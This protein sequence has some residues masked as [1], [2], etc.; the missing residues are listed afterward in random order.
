MRCAPAQERNIVLPR[1]LVLISQFTYFLL[2]HS[3]V[4]M[5]PG[6][7]GMES[8]WMFESSAHRLSPVFGGAPNDL[9]QRDIDCDSAGKG[10]EKLA[11][12][13]HNK[14]GSATL[15]P[16]TSALSRVRVYVDCDPVMHR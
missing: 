13:F 2:V 6:T 1:L 3:K 8:S 11:F 10:I 16:I 9:C 12:R 5:L 15:S 4:H 14:G 7:I